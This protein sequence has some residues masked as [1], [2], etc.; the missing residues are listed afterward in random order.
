MCS[1]NGS[2]CDWFSQKC[3]N[4]RL[5]SLISSFSPTDEGL[6]GGTAEQLSTSLARASP[7]LRKCV[8]SCKRIAESTRKQNNFQNVRS[9]KFFS[10]HHTFTCRVFAGLHQ[11]WS[12]IS[13]NTGERRVVPSGPCLR[14]GLL[15]CHSDGVFHRYYWDLPH[16]SFQ[17][18]SFLTFPG[19]F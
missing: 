11:F 7:E 15:S 18:A 1:P 6:E 10:F 16:G 14:Q 3:A 13:T 5:S 12:L 8:A 17:P 9:V 19:R 2:L 4:A